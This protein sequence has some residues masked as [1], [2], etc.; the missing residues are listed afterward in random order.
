MITSHND[1]VEHH[2]AVAVVWWS[3]LTVE[4]KSPGEAFWIT[5]WSLVKRRESKTL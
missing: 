3:V 4:S 2:T 1:A 5:D